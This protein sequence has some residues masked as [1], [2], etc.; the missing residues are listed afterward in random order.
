[1]TP[2]DIIAAALHQAGGDPVKALELLAHDCSELLKENAY[3][4]QTTRSGFNRN[5]MDPTRKARPGS[6][7]GTPSTESSKD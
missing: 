4:L 5:V 1:M 7:S 3:L 6:G 2:A